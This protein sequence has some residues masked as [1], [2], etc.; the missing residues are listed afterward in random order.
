MEQVFIELEHYDQTSADVVGSRPHDFSFD[1]SPRAPTLAHQRFES[2]TPLRRLQEL[3]WRTRACL[4]DEF[5]R[6]VLPWVRQRRVRRE[7]S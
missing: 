7:T 3:Y 2:D 4:L 5:R 6:H 1:T